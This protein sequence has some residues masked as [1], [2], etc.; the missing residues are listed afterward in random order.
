MTVDLHQNLDSKRVRLSGQF[1][2]EVKVSGIMKQLVFFAY[3]LRPAGM[4]EYGSVKLL[5]M[6]RGSFAFG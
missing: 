3:Q 6:L 1:R 2:D 4:H 5:R